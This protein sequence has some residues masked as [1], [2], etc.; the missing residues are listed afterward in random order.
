ML[1][2]VFRLFLLFAVLAAVLGCDC[3]KLKAG[4]CCS[5]PRGQR[6]CHSRKKRSLE[7]SYETEFERRRYAPKIDLDGN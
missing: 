3:S 4:E 6:C 5:N 7:D 1:H 2:F